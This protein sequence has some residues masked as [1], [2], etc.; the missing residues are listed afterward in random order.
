MGSF[1]KT[2]VHQEMSGEAGAGL[3]ST[4]AALLAVQHSTRPQGPPSLRTKTHARSPSVNASK[5]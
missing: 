2:L 1:N 3:Q 4:A 5:K